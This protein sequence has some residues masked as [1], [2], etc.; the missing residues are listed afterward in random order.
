MPT[1]TRTCA[2]ALGGAT[3]ASAITRPNSVI[4]VLFNM[5]QTSMF[6]DYSKPTPVK[7]FRFETALFPF[8]FAADSTPLWRGTIVYD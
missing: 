4:I 1:P 7:K 6:C 8:A 2:L 5:F 3:R